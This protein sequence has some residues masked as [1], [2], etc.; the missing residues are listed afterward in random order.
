MICQVTRRG[1]DQ[2]KDGLAGLLSGRRHE[3]SQAQSPSAGAVY[4]LTPELG[5]PKCPPGLP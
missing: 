5:S 2:V 1:V 4:P 3:M